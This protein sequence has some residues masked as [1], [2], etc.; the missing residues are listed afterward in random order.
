VVQN[1]TK[2]TLQPFAG[3]LMPPGTIE[4]WPGK[5]RIAVGKEIPTEGLT[6]DGVQAL[7]ERTFGVMKGMI[8]ENAAREIV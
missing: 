3:R 5:I 1:S 6:T 8:E 7:K 4:L 2:E